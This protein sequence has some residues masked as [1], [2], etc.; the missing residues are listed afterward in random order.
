MVLTFDASRSDGQGA[1]V[2]YEPA[3]PDHTLISATMAPLEG[4]AEAT[5]GAYCWGQEDEEGTMYEAQVRLDGGEAQI[6]RVTETSG[7]SALART[8]EVHG[9]VPYDL[10]GEDPSSHDLPY[11]ADLGEL[12]TNNLKF[13]CEYTAEDGEDPHMRLRLWVN[14]ELVLSATDEEP[15][16]DND[17]LDDDERRMVGLIQRAS[18]GNERVAV[19]Y[20]DFALYRIN[21]E[22]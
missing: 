2:P 18:V 11:R 20:T 1:R 9:F 3:T 13:A 5:A 10:F 14:D 6:R 21:V 4:P 12:V 17:E 16:P 22:E 19:A 15:L 8:T 7:E